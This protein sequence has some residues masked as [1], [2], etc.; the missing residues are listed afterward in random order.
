MQI[1]RIKDLAPD[2][3]ERLMRRAGA[4]VQRVM[5]QV[6]EI[7]ADVRERGD[8]ALREYAARFDGAAVG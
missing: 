8:A 1:T 4:D 5:P 6:Q 2:A 7:M 3:Y